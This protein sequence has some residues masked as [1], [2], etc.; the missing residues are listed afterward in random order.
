MNLP[1]PFEEL[2]SNFPLLKELYNVDQYKNIFGIEELT[3]KESFQNFEQHDIEEEESE[4]EIES[5]EEPSGKIQNIIPMKRKRPSS[6]R[7][8]KI[9]KFVNPNKQLSVPSTSTQKPLLRPQDLFESIDK[10]E[11]KKLELKINSNMPL[12]E[13][14]SSFHV[15]NDVQEGGFGLIFPANKTDVKIPDESE[16]VEEKKEQEFITSE[17]LSN[18]RISI[19]G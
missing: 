9:P 4:S 7:K 16:N 10:N 17:E 2:E 18:N 3:Q 12:L 19:K 15:S 8:M 6:S 14:T 1:P 13:S 11:P 5:E